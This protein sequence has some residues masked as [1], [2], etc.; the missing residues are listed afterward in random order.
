MGVVLIATKQEELGIKQFRKALEIQ[1]DIQVTK[2]LANPEIVKAFE[3]AAATVADRRRRRRWRRRNVTAAGRRRQTRAAEVTGRHHA[4]PG[5]AAVAGRKPVPISATVSPDLKGYT[6]VVLAYRA[7]GAPDFI[8][9]DMQRSGNKFTAEIPAEAT[10]GSVVH[11]YVEAETEDENAVAT[12]G[13]EEKPYAIALSAGG[14]GGTSEPAARGGEGDSDEEGG[15][16]F[17]SLSGG[18][19]FRIRHGHRRAERGQP[20]EHS[21]P[22]HRRCRSCPRW[23]TSCRRSSGCRCRRV[24]SM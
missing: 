7:E 4:R 3:D 17:F 21:S 13:S 8:G 16:F 10:N 5:D 1:P 14:T 18:H 20:C 6:K 19:R 23:V 9:V 11:Y 2:A 12:N 15:K 22:P 24:F